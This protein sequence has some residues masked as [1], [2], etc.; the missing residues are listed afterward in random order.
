MVLK[1]DKIYQ[2]LALQF[3]IHITIILRDLVKKVQIIC[4]AP[5]GYARWNSP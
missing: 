3:L 1:K 2:P 4:I 5:T